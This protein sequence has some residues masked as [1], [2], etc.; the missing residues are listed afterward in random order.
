MTMMVLRSGTQLATESA[1]DRLPS[2]RQPE[3]PKMWMRKS[4]VYDADKIRSKKLEAGCYR[5]EHTPTGTVFAVV[6]D[7]K[8]GPDARG[9]WFAINFATDEVVTVA[10]KRDDVMKTL[11]SW[12]GAPARF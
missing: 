11:E 9:R 3:D 1:A 4:Q 7:K 10:R 6:N 8:L 5:V 2:T 12:K